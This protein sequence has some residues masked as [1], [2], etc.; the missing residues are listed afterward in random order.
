MENMILA[1]TTRHS[2]L[3]ADVTMSDPLTVNVP[4]LPLYLLYG[5][6]LQYSISS[7]IRPI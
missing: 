1:I 4:C 7:A 2:I 3:T 5:G 6:I